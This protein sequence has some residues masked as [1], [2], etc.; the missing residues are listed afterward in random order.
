MLLGQ[1]DINIDNKESENY[2]EHKPDVESGQIDVLEEELISDNNQEERKE[3][4]SAIE[5]EVCESTSSDI[6]ENIEIDTEKFSSDFVTVDYDYFDDALFIGDSRTVGLMEYGNLMNAT[7]WAESGMSVFKLEKKILQPDG[8]KVG[9]DKILSDRQ[10]GKIYLMLGINELG[11]KFEAFEKKYK[12]TVEYI[13]EHQSGA[14]LFLCA[15]MHVTE[16]QS[17]KDATFNNTNVNRVNEMIAGLADGKTN[18]YIDVNEVFD[19]EKGNLSMEYSSDTFHVYGKYYKTWS[20]W[21]CT[22][23]IRVE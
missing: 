13:S 17:Q 1:E 10:Y 7:F 12:E 5:Q 6:N 14:I 19:D 15:N 23:A 18:F 22:K 21:L 16:S 9:L 8:N 11:Y 2:F 3:T 20:D 4:L